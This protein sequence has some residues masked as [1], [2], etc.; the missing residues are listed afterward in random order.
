MLRAVLFPPVKYWSGGLCLSL[1]RLGLFCQLG[2]AGGVLHGDVG[3]DLAVQLD[4]GLL[5]SVDELRVAGAVQLG[6]GGDADDPQR[7]EL[8]LLLRRPV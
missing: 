4:A 1:R 2:K 5:Q 7:A 3:Q 6:G 8:A